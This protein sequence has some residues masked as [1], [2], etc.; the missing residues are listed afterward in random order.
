MDAGRPAQSSFSNPRP[1]PGTGC[2]PKGGDVRCRGVHVSILYCWRDRPGILFLAHTSTTMCPSK[3]S[4]SP[5]RFSWGAECQ[6][7][8]GAT[9][10]RQPRS[11]EGRG[12]REG[13]TCLLR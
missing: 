1:S 11:S 5:K 9:S 4:F 7:D 3:E 2:V 8:R 12:R 6:P 13:G 10:G